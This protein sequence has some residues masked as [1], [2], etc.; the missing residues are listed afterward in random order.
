MNASLYLLNPI[1]L[2][3]GEE[4]LRSA[5]L[6]GSSLADSAPLACPEG[7]EDNRGGSP[8][9]KGDPASSEP[10]LARPRRR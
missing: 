4:G 1:G 3:S 2:R 10:H 6:M 5:L 8:R 7:W 9:G